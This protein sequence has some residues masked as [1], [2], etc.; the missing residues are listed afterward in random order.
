[1]GL[2]FTIIVCILIGWTAQ[3]W[4]GRTGAGWF[5]ISVLLMFG[6]MFLLFV[7][8]E[9]HKPGLLDTD[10]GM[11]ALWLMT[12]FIGGGIMLVVVAT[13]PSKKSKGD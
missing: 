3:S 7:S 13:L 2:L 6:V 9:M 8:V 12:N 10:S 5:L 1:M 4:K 11:I